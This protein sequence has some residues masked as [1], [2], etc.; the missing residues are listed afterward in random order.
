MNAK[1]HSLKLIGLLLLTALNACGGGGGGS[2]DSATTSVSP[3]A[4]N[5]NG[6]STNGSGTSG[7][8]TPGTTPPGT[9][10]P[11]TTTPGT[12]TPGGNTAGSGISPCFN[13]ALF[14]KGTTYRWN[15]LSNL[16]TARSVELL[17]ITTAAY[18]GH[19]DAVDVHTKVSAPSTGIETEMHSY[20]APLNGAT[21]VLYGNTAEG[22]LHGA[23][24]FT[25]SQEYDPSWTQKMFT[26]TVPGQ[27]DEFSTTIHQTVNNV[28]RDQALH[29]KATYLGQE[30][31]TVAA[32][33]FVDACKFSIEEGSASDVGK[34][35]AWYAKGSGVPIKSTATSA[36]GSF[37][38]ELQASSL[39]NGQP[40]R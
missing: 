13:P 28:R 2:D 34:T 12:T 32:G 39:L 11:G 7:S 30:T 1:T 16:G 5:N 31:V 17:S 6:A 33:T 35:T 15:Y 22:R 14:A 10:T 3:P 20:N 24:T 27:I 40:V 26:L 4:T 23:L 18:Q 21:L 25:S 36:E 19:A 29:W 37:S 8:T 9:T 38:D